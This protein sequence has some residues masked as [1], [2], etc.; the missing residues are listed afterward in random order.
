LKST[1]DPW[2]LLWLLENWKKRRSL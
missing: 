2:Y 1:A